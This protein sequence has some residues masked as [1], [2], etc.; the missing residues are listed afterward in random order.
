MAIVCIPSIKRKRC[1]ETLGTPNITFQKC[2]TIL[3][4]KITLEK[5][6][7]VKI[8]ITEFMVEK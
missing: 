8:L 3:S 1:T 5:G 2:R 7:I 6:N 4:V